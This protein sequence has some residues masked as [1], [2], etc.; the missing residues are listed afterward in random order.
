[1]STLPKSAVRTA[2]TPPR[3]ASR[4]VR[5]R[6]LIEATI[7]SIAQHGIGGTT[8]NT[9]TEFLGL[10]LGIVNFHFKNSLSL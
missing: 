3:T 8:M 4:E 1:M 5:R 6:Q 2:G 7:N 10:S 9:V